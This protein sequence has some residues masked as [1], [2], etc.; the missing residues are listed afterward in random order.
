MIKS[1]FECKKTLFI[2]I[3]TAIRE[4]DYKLILAFMALEKD[5]QIFIGQTAVID[6]I[7]CNIKNGVIIGKNFISNLPSYKVET[8]KQFH[9]NNIKMLFLHEEAGPTYVYEDNKQ[10][11]DSYIDPNDLRSE[12][13]IFCWGE[14]DYNHY[15]S[16]V[17]VNEA[18]EIIR[19]GNPRLDVGINRH[20][21]LFDEEVKS[22]RSQYKKIILINTNFSS[23]A[24]IG[25]DRSL[26]HISKYVADGNQDLMFDYIRNFTHCNTLYSYFIDL[27]LELSLKFKDHKIVLRPHPSEDERLYN[28]FFKHIPNAT[29]TR[30]GSLVAWL[31]ASDCVIAN[32]CTTLLEAFRFGTPAINYVPVTN[33]KLVVPEIEVSSVQCKELNEVIYLV[34]DVISKKDF[35]HNNREK[36]KLLIRSVANFDKD[37]DSFEI[38]AEKLKKSLQS[39]PASEIIEKKTSVVN[40]IKDTLRP[41]KHLLH[42]S[43]NKDNELA[44]RRHSATKMAG[45]DENNLATKISLLNKHYNTNVS[46]EWLD[47]Q[48]AVLK[49]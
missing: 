46:I 22:I 47:P 34:S 17:L 30:E 28:C 38:I 4:L 24:I 15:K 44:G 40:K 7:A 20:A 35:P 33:D 3:E 31:L 12:D 27:V 11:F 13:Y 18:C 48:L 19:S 37:V 1:V 14:H 43:E 42:R 9:K 23:Q 25:I 45:F 8:Y 2:P 36:M 6:Q 26:D 29:V 49:S 21:Y 32:Y 39:V 16:K 41:I 5:I 10:R